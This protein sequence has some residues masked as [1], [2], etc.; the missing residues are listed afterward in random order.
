MVLV[1]F[2]LDDDGAVSI[3]AENVV[4]VEERGLDR[5]NIITTHGVYIVRG[6]REEVVSRLNNGGYSPCGFIQY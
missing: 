3:N 1:D 6:S 5:S 2:A 4:L